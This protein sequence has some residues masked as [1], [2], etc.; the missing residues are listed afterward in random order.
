M[1][2]STKLID[3]LR[4]VRKVSRL[5]QRSLYRVVEQMGHHVV[6]QLDFLLQRLLVI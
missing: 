3:I 2:L 4:H 5:R 1:K 6:Q